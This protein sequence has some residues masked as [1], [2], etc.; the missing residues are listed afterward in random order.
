MHR[1]RCVFLDYGSERNSIL[2]ALDEGRKKPEGGSP[3]VMV[4]SMWSTD[5][6]STLQELYRPLVEE[7][8]SL[9][10]IARLMLEEANARPR[11]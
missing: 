11:H 3:A 10:T 2:Q 5:L 6:A 4:G 9:S 7:G 8:F 1:G